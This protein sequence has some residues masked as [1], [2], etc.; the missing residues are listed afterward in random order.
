MYIKELELENFKSFRNQKFVLKPGITAITGPNGSG[1]SN[2]FDAILFVVGNNSS[3]KLR[4]KKIS[5]LICKDQ[6]EKH[7]SVRLTFSD[8]TIIERTITEDV[9]VF[10]LNGK[11]TTQEAIVSFLKELKISADG[12]NFVQQG[13][14]KRIVDMSDFERKKLIEDLAGVSSF[15]EQKEKS[16]KNLDFV[17]IKINQAKVILDE[18]KEMLD[19][20]AKEKAIAENYLQVKELEVSLKAVLLKKEKQILERELK[21]TQTRIENLTE[22]IPE[23][24]TLLQD[25][26]LKVRTIKKEILN[27]K[28]NNKDKYN[29]ETK[30]K[31]EIDVL[32]YKLEFLEKEI[33]SIKIKTNEKQSKII[34]LEQKKEKSQNINKKI[35]ELKDV[36]NSLKLK[37]LNLEKSDFYNN[38]SLDLK[39]KDILEK[40]NKVSNEIYHLKEQIKFSEEEF[41]LKEKTNLEMKI[42]LDNL[43]SLKE[44]DFKVSKLKTELESLETEFSKL[45]IKLQTLNESLSI[46]KEEQ[47]SLKSRLENLDKEEDLLKSIQ[48]NNFEIK[49]VPNEKEINDI[50]ANLEKKN[51]FGTFYFVLDKNKEALSK[52]IVKQISIKEK[53]DKL[54]NNKEKLKLNI[55]KANAKINEFVGLISEVKSKIEHLDSKIYDLKDSLNT[56]IDLESKNNTKIEVLTEKL[57]NLSTK[58]FNLL[59]LEKLNSRLVTLNKEYSNYQEFLK[60]YEEFNLEY[61]KVSKNY[62]DNIENLQELEQ[63]NKE[64]LLEESIAL[65]TV[66]NLSNDILELER[67]LYL[68]ENAKKDLL[69]ILDKANIN[70]QNVSSELKN[71]ESKYLSEQSNL[72]E[73]EDQKNKLNLEL[74]LNENELEEQRKSIFLKDDTLLKK[75][76]EIKNYIESNKNVDISKLEEKYSEYENLSI[77][78]LTSKYYDTLTSLNEFGNV[79]LK[80]IEDYGIYLEKYGL[81]IERV[82]QLEKES[83]EI[84]EKIKEIIAQ[85]EIKFYECFNNLN[86]NFIEFLSKVNMGDISLDV[87]KGEEVLGVSIKSKSRRTISLSGG[88]KS[89]IT[90]SFLLSTLLL[91][92][93]IFYLVDEIDADLDY[94]NS[95][96]VYDML[97]A[98][99]KDTQIMMVTHNPVIINKVESVI[100]VSKSSQGITTVFLKQNQTNA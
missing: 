21:K 93:S 77:K 66:N 81:I 16:E 7:A 91:E 22:M 82:D 100:G 55:D 33:H 40:S 2:I 69:T 94:N 38:K 54:Y 8:G 73:L 18:R 47:I 5:D 90:I 25:L 34:E 62:S 52:I 99:A 59:D 14:N 17:K 9:S 75:V 68:K 70:L 32:N 15:D 11:R 65:N 72:D 37:I 28:E 20:L 35:E 98:F 1:K 53:L 26:D 57:N 30:I 29:L 43:K 67:E 96:K 42:I 23:K 45:N 84:K 63:K 87:I 44:E 36:V 56:A 13:N 76:D 74:S 31:S 24:R 60:E 4:Y 27:F 46:T 6:K 41:K 85:K 78:D 97:S 80:S 19:N 92:T 48:E 61:S 89:L 12:M 79:N 49:V 86:K 95:E 83:N 50:L 71:L 51:L 64:L 10:R 58:N 3:N 39:R 88:E